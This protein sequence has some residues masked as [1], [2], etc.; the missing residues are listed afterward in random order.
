MICLENA[1]TMVITQ[2]NMPLEA[3]SP[4]TGERTKNP[5]NVSWF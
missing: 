4:I 3:V 1:T 5:A 2:L